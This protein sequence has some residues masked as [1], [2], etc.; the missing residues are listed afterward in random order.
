MMRTGASKRHRS[1]SAL[2]WLRPLECILFRGRKR[3]AARRAMPSPDKTALINSL[4]EEEEDDEQI[5]SNNSS[6]SQYLFN[7]SLSADSHDFAGPR[8]FFPYSESRVASYSRTFDV[9]SDIDSM[10]SEDE[11]KLRKSLQSL[12]KSNRYRVPMDEE[13]NEPNLGNMLYNDYPLSHDF[14]DD[15][16]HFSTS[17]ETIRSTFTTKISVTESGDAPPSDRSVNTSR[18]SITKNSRV[19]LDQFMADEQKIVQTSI[20]NLG[21]ISA[22]DMASVNS[23]M[24]TVS[25]DDDYPQLVMQRSHDGSSRFSSAS[26]GASYPHPAADNSSV[27]SWDTTKK[28]VTCTST[29]LE[30]N[31]D[32]VWKQIDGE[33]ED[34]GTCDGDGNSRDDKGTALD[35]D[36]NQDDGA[37][38]DEDE[39]VVTMEDDG[40]AGHSEEDDQTDGESTVASRSGSSKESIKDAWEDS[41]TA[42]ISKSFSPEASV[43]KSIS[44]MIGESVLQP[45]LR[46]LCHLV[47]SIEIPDTSCH[48]RHL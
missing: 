19:S 28:V 22:L 47:D 9:D 37:T 25:F 3:S 10:S 38:L 23:G 34:E 43:G 12:L 44:D 8:S 45:M 41:D 27:K 39:D 7:N 14:D 18:S 21:E 13:N 6:G 4:N 30:A 40:D 35:D 32:K 29:W 24:M 48:I 42:N 26:L 11:I 17:T 33:T 46:P 16:H 20:M 2:S 5:L 36:A 31:I 1:S 15:T